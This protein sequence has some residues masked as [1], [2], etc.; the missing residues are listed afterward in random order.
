[1]TAQGAGSR[2]DDLLAAA[3]R[4]FVAQGI[5]RTTMEDIAR[6]AGAGKATLYRY[7]ANKDA[8]V[9][10]LLERESERFQRRMRRAVDEHGGGLTGLQAAFIAGVR[11]FTTHPLLTRGRD[12]DPGLLLERIAASRGPLVDAGLEWFAAE[13]A[14][15]KEAGEVR[16]DVD[17]EVA[18]EVLMRLVLSYFSF[19]PMVLD[20]DD[21]EQV[22][23][24]AREIVVRSLGRVSATRSG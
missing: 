4:R 17:P 18:A 9:D 12:E 6:E 15:S 7:F 10:A 23:I 3:A 20:V 19:R 5:R 2:R 22:K 1:M 8:V 13:I 14:A 21:D 24:L 16:G 11:F